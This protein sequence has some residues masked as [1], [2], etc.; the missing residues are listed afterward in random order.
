MKVEGYEEDEALAQ[1]H[2]AEP[3]VE[4]VKADAKSGA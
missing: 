4:Q 3:P 1:K 2:L